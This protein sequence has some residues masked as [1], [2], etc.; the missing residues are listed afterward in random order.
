M[1]PPNY[2]KQYYRD[3]R[4]AVARGY[5]ELPVFAQSHGLRHFLLSDTD[6]DQHGFI[7]DIVDVKKLTSSAPYRLAVK[8]PMAQ[9]FEIESAEPLR[10]SVSPPVRR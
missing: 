5:A 4:D 6:L 1:L 9:L 8:A 10:G 7:S 2:P 3:D